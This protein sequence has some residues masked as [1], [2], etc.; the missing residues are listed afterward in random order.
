MLMRFFTWLFPRL[1]PCRRGR[2]TPTIVHRVRLQM[3]GGQA[4][5]CLV[6]FVE[7]NLACALCDHPIDASLWAEIAGPQDVESVD[8]AAEQWS[9][10]EAGKAVYLP[11][12]DEAG[13]VIE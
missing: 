6:A 5:R 7:T 10:L 9:Q 11:P 4:R 13:N 3:I 8:L 2:H 12:V 1:H